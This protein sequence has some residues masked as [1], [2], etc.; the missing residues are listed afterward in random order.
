MMDA[1]TT[2]VPVENDVLALLLELGTS[3]TESFNDTLRR[4]L[5]KLKA[6]VKSSQPAIPRDT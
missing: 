4:E 2:L 3:P 5:P 1:N 6:L